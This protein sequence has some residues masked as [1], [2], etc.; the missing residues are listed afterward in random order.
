M[1]NANNSGTIERARRTRGFSG[2]S[3]VQTFN[4][5]LNKYIRFLV[6]HMFL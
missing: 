6:L 4:C 1:H 5:Q 2:F 3:V